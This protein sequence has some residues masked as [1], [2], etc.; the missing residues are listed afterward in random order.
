LG[1]GKVFSSAFTGDFTSFTGDVSGSGGSGPA[2]GAVSAVVVFTSTAAGLTDAPQFSQNL[3]FG[4][5]AAPH[6]GHTGKISIFAP[7]DSQNF[8]SGVTGLPH[9]W[10]VRGF[11]VMNIHLTD[12]EQL[13]ILIQVVTSYHSICILIL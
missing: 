4:T 5:S 11:A 3:I 12:S 2:T 10:Q 6:C 7:Q 1:T 8:I 9:F 13:S